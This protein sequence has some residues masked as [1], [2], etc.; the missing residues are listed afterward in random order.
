MQMKIKNFFEEIAFLLLSVFLLAGLIAFQQ[1]VRERHSQLSALFSSS[2]GQK[3]EVRSLSQEELVSLVKPAVVRVVTY[4]N[5]EVT[6]PAFD[7]DLKKFNITL[8]PQRK[9]FKLELDDY[10]TGSGFAVNPEGYIVTNSHVVSDETVKQLSLIEPIFSETV[11]ATLKLPLK[12]QKE[13]RTKQEELDKF[14]REVA[15]F[16]LAKSTFSLEKKVVV[17]K[18]SSSKEKLEDLFLDGFRARVLSVN[19]KFFEDDRDV[20]LLKIEQS[21]LPAL[22]L[23][24]SN[25]LASGNNI[26]VF[27]FPATAEFNRKNLLEATFTQG[28]VSAVKDS[29]GKDF[30]VFQTDAKVSQGSSGGPLFNGQG[31][32]LGLV[33]FQTDFQ[34]QSAGDNFAFAIPVELVRDVLSARAVEDAPGSY[35]EHFMKGLEFY[36]DKHCRSAISEFDQAGQ[37]NSDFK[38]EEFLGPYLD[39]CDAFIASGESIDSVWD[40]IEN[41][42]KN[43]DSRTIWIGSGSFLVVAVLIFILFKLRRRVRKGEN[44]MQHLE[45]LMVTEKW[46]RDADE[47]VFRLSSSNG[48]RPRRVPPSEDMAGMA[49]PSQSVPG[50][51]PQLK[52]YIN[53]A[54]Q[55]GLSDK[56]IEDELLKVGWLGQDIS[57][58]L[59]K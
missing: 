30:R 33:T 23:G 2:S 45:E 43:L 59:G 20:A 32:V 15:D 16:L 17:L 58:A 27:G 19:D 44:D 55:S 40:E 26:F 7:L 52:T 53:Q 13:L 29:S 22:R 12:D 54:R 25:G 50:I 36:R 4:F 9:P 3:D 28:V 41:K 34:R 8:T 18:P 39:K 14:G 10:F 35:Q 1:E 57:R 38:L 6:V 48:S 47:D 31:E 37:A 11:K 46:Q 51:D 24:S 5:G 49:S 56:A 21:G 42:V